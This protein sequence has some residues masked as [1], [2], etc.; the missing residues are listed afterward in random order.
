VAVGASMTGLVNEHGDL[1]TPAKNLLIVATGFA[2]IMIGIIETVLEKTDNEPMHHLT[3]PL[4]KGITGLAILSLYFATE[5]ISS[6]L[7]MISI[8][9][10]LGINM[11]YGLYKWFGQEIEDDPVEC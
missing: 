2:I 9:I 4:L 6:K 1:A 3:S 7:L 5:H 11:M 10:I 8:L